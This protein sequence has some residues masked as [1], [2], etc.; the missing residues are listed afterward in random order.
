VTDKP[1]NKLPDNIVAHWPE[2]FN[3]IELRVVPIK[4]LH[5]VKVYFSDGKIWDVD[6][7]K[8][9]KSQNHAEIEQSLT[10]LFKAQEDVIE[11]ID[12]RLD[13]NKIKE[14]IQK[15]T[16]SFLKRKR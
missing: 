4:Y 15:Q 1:K 6:V 5:S 13:V 2:I 9:K 7:E 11:Y 14:D 16:M 8:T 10:N 12:F 3:D